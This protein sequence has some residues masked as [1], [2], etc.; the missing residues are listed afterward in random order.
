MLSFAL[1]K[2]VGK[3]EQRR[4]HRSGWSGLGQTTFQWVVGLV[5]RLHWYP[6]VAKYTCIHCAAG[7]D[8]VHSA[9]SS[10]ASQS[11]SVWKVLN[12]I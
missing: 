10:S 4:H 8:V 7:S 11:P 5:P 2:K 1:A 3:G 6:R 12:C 9:C